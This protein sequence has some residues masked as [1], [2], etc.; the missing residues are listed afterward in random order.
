MRGISGPYLAA[1]VLA[2]AV[3]SSCSR[4]TQSMDSLAEQYVRLTLAVGQHDADYVDAYYGP[5]E[6]KPGEKKSSLDEISGRVGELQSQL[7]QVPAASDEMLELRRQYLT[8]QV[9]AMAARIRML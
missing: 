8:K 9:S 1:V 3:V 2:A 6:W 5:A 4:P 7:S